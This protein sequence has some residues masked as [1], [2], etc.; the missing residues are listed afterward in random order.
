MGKLKKWLWLGGVAAVAAGGM[1]L[2]RGSVH[3]ADR[4]VIVGVG[5]KRP[6]KFI[7]AKTLEKIKS[8]TNSNQ[9]FLFMY[10]T[11]KD[12]TYDKYTIWMPVEPGDQV[13][14]A[15]GCVVSYSGGI[16]SIDLIVNTDLMAQKL[17]VLEA[18]QKV[19]IVARRCIAYALAG[20]NLSASQF[21]NVMGEVITATANEN[22][23]E[24]H[25]K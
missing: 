16:P 9:K 7:S 20:E 25:L 13:N 8:I 4:T 23:F 6:V 11:R 17:Q 18:N 10:L 3:V 21:E 19:N 2:M 12:L 15:A 1:L 24:V 14:I 22:L 5:E